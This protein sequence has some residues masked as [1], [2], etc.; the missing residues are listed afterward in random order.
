MNFLK[1]LSSLLSGSAQSPSGVFYPIVA[2]CNR[3]GEIVH[4][5]INLNNDLSIEYAEN[6]EPTG[7]TCRKVL[8]GS[9]RCFQQIEVTLTFNANR[10]L[11]NKEITGGKFADESS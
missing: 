3:C 6:G 7:Y 10:V 11:T 4:G 2:R 5:Q 1:S 8:M 9:G